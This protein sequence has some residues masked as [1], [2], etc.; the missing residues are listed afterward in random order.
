MKVDTAYVTQHFSILATPHTDDFWAKVS[1][2]V[3]WTVMG[4]HALSGHY[5]SLASFQQSTFSR[6]SA[7]M[8]DGIALH[9][10]QVIVDPTTKAACVELRSESTQKS[11]KPFNNRYA[12]VVRYNDDGVIDQVRAY[13]DGHLVNQAIEENPGP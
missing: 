11:G 3:D 10:V 13:L 1:P 7:R 5:T 6:L 12:W 2:D 9:L 8:A 4:S